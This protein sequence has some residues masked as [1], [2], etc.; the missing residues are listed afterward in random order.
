MSDYNTHVMTGIKKNDSSML[1]VFRDELRL[2]HSRNKA[3]SAFE[4]VLLGDKRE[5][6]RGKLRATGLSVEQQVEALVDHA[7]DPNILGRTYAGWEP[8]V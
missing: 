8:W 6:A 7:T 1:L 5:N 2:G 4:S 3:F